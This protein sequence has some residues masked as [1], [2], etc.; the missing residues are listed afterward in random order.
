[1][2]DVAAFEQ[3]LY[4]RLRNTANF[5][6]G[7][8]GAAQIPT[9]AVSDVMTAYSVIT[10]QQKVNLADP[11]LSRV[12]LRPAVDRHNCGANASCDAIAARILSGIRAWAHAPRDAP[13]TASLMSSKT[14]F[15]AGSAG[16]LRADGNLVAKFDFD[17]GSGT[18]TADTSGVGAPITLQ[19]QG[20]EWVDGGLRNLTGRAQANATDSSKL[21]GMI[22]PTGAFTIE[23]WIAPANVTQAGPAR[24]VS[25]SSGTA[26]SNFRWVRT[27]AGIGSAI[28][29]REQRRRR[30]VPRSPEQPTSWPS[31]SRS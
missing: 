30:S 14:S 7:C 12:Y 5:C 11:E 26:T 2:S 19:L 23:A 1:M 10:T 31:C 3:T 6:V 20:M 8:H 27:R 13:P 15:G 21:F 17:E 18:T 25:Y 22:M 9:F 28:V 16:S 29:L 4:P 24:I